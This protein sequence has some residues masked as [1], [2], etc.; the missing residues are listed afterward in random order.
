MKTLFERMLDYLDKL[1]SYHMNDYH[2][3]LFIK[4]L[5]EEEQFIMQALIA[6]GDD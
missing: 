2:M 6:M 4:G 5:P 1:L 3:S